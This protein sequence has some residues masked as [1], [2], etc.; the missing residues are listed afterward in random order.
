VP[1]TID[2]RI[3]YGEESTDT[4]LHC[5]FECGLQIWLGTSHF[6]RLDFQSHSS[7]RVLSLFESNERDRSFRIPQDRYAADSWSDLF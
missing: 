3:S 1:V 4:A 2:E 5:G 7:C 6:Q